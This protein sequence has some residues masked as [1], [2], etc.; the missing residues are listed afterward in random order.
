[1]FTVRHPEDKEHLQILLYYQPY[2]PASD[3]GALHTSQHPRPH[4][5]EQPRFEK[6]SLVT[7]RAQV[8]KN[9][10]SWKLYPSR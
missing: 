9:G 8:I 3:K 7:E 10:P 2:T 6:P 4:R 5:I 1:M